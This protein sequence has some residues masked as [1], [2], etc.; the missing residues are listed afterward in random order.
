MS[1]GFGARARIGH[2]YPSGGLVD[3]EVQLMAP[4]GVQLVTTR[5][6][7]RG[8]TLADDL[9]LLDDLEEH[10]RLLADAEVGLIAM[11]CTAATMLAGAEAVNA[12]I[13][14]ST[15][16]PSTT[17]IEAVLAALAAVGA[18]RIALLTPYLPEVTEAETA[19]LAERAIEVVAHATLPLATPVEQGGQDPATWLELARGL[20]GADADALLV[21]C[22]GIR[23]APVLADMEAA[24]GRPVVASNQALL[25]QCLRLTDV[26][27]RPAG[28]GT[29]LAGAFG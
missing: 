2:L 16:I 29:L 14:A 23:L 21:S 11:N 8:S 9:A 24:F 18:R 1:L 12:R 15:G 26:P 13:A 22:A 3:Y 17:T 6:P 25:W 27:D 28:F 7:Y 20:G 10:S 19:F 5:M 4:E